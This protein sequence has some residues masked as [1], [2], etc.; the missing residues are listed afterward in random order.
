[1]KD[2]GLKYNHKFSHFVTTL[3]SRKNCSID[4]TAKNIKDSDFLSILYSKLLWD[5]M[6][7]KFKI[8]DRMRISKYDVNFRKGYKPQY[9]K[10]VF[11]IVAIFS[12]N[13]QNT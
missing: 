8:G 3:K 1:M 7:P 10:E 11:E 4:L 6:K 9:K 5:F 12:E 2:F 13:L